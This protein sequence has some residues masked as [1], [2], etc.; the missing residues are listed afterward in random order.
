MANRWKLGNN[1]LDVVSLV[2]VAALTEETVVHNTVDIKLVQ[3]RIAILFGLAS[4]NVTQGVY[5]C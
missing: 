3:K 4:Q 2:V 1:H 5:A